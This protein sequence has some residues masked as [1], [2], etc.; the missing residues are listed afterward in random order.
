MSG[1]Q[2]LALLACAAFSAGARVEDAMT[3]GISTG[4]AVAFGLCFL[5]CLAVEAVKR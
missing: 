3:A 4:A 5:Y 1:G 2:T